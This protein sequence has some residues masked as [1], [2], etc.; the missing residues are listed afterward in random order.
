MYP[1]IGRQILQETPTSVRTPLKLRNAVIRLDGSIT[2][3]RQGPDQ[4]TLDSA[5]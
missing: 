5:L 3:N 1:G 4:T 2:L